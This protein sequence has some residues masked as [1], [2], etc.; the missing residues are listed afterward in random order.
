VWKAGLRGCRFALTVV[1]SDSLRSSGPHPV[2]PFGPPST[3]RWGRSGR[4]LY[5]RPPSPR[6]GEGV[7]RSPTDG[8]WK[9]GLRG[10]RFT[11]TV[12]QSDSLRSSGP[13]PIRPLGPPSPASWGRSGGASDER[14]PHQRHHHGETTQRNPL[15]G[16]NEPSWEARAL[17]HPTSR[18]SPAL[19]G[20]PKPIIQ[21]ERTSTPF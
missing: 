4:A 11:L 15:C 7:G 19:I 20:A 12:V 3:A 5:P 21:L 2:R 16:R 13:H 1:Q 8:V 14:V 10:C 6:S 18:K 9:A 17:Q